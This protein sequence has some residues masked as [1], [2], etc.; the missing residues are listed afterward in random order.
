MGF[1][2]VKVIAL[3]GISATML[4]SRSPQNR[5]GIS[6]RGGVLLTKSNLP[7]LGLNRVVSVV[8][9]HAKIRVEKDV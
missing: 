9:R 6:L 7:T 3:K 4:M 8:T 2:L 5:G 1:T